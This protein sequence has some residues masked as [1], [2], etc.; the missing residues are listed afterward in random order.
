MGNYPMN[1]LRSLTRRKLRTALTVIGIAVGIWALVVMAALATKLSAIVESSSTYFRDKVV[2]TDA[3]GTPFSTVGALTPLTI[4]IVQQ[5]EKVP[6]VAVAVPRVMLPMN[7]DDPGNAFQLPAYILGYTEGADRGYE[8]S[9]MRVAMGR[10]TGPGD[11]G[12]QV[13]FLGSDLAR[14]FD[15]RPGDTFEIRGIEFTVVGVGEPRLMTFDTSVVIP[16]SEAQAML[17]REAPIVV[18]RELDPGQLTS[19][20]I[21]YP[22]NGMDTGL[23]AQRIEKTVP[24]VR[25]GTSTDFD[26]QFGSTLAIFNA[27]ILSVALIS[28][29]VGGLS[30]VNTM[31]ISVAERTREIGIKRA[32]GAS[33]ARIMR[34]LLSEAAFIGLIG[35]LVGLASGAAFIYGANQVGETSGTVLFLLTSEI[36]IL[37]LAFSTALGTVAGA[38]PAW[39]ASGLD[40]IEA[41]RYE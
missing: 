38:L 18:G 34:E 6:G 5:I 20:V 25:A 22:D 37:A 26:N 19:T 3:T 16:L 14:E 35:G 40:P 12:Q 11:E 30:V 10:A 33:R 13:V 17:Y 7:P 2:V 31:T 9:P 1:L 23:L 41:L 32:I 29:V 39:N 27:I 4:D 28:V 24:K 15:K 36:A 21:V 8:T